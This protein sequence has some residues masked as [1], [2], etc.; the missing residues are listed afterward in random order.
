MSKHLGKTRSF[1]LLFTLIFA[2]LVGSQGALAIQ[3]YDLELSTPVTDKT[4]YTSTNHGPDVAEYEIKIDNKGE[5]DD[6]YKFTYSIPEDK[7]DYWSVLFK[8]YDTNEV[9]FTDEPEFSVASLETAYMIMTVEPTCKCQ[10]GETLILELTGQSNGYQ[11][12]SETLV[13]KITYEGE[14]GGDPNNNN[15]VDPV[16]KDTDGDGWDDE[17]EL[18]YGTDPNDP[19]SHPDVDSDKDGLPDIQEDKLGTDIL[20]PDT[21]GDGESDY[22]EWRDGTDPLD[23]SDNS[24]TGISNPDPQQPAAQEKEETNFLG[25]KISNDLYMLLIPVLIF[26]IVISIII[27][28]YVWR[29]QDQVEEN[30]GNPKD[31]RL[32][33]AG[34]YE[35]TRNKT[36]PSNR[37][38]VLDVK[39]KKSGAGYECPECGRDFSMKALKKHV[40]RAHHKRL[41]R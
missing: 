24:K 36:P 29:K 4:V 15:N 21:D 22:V 37:I 28:S 16:D 31:E 25:L 30:A 14:H 20:N 27:L 23:S 9:L 3:F 1:G 13:L 8:D 26:I 35:K 7:V 17:S 33:E 5:N 11:P 18:E 34:L 38:E 40:L 10:I 19:N 32:D 2:V 12:E 41:K 39:L 6:V